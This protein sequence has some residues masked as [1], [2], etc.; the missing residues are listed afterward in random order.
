MEELPTTTTLIYYAVATITVG[1]AWT[2][3]ANRL[4]KLMAPEKTAEGWY[5]WIVRSIAVLLC[6]GVGWYIGDAWGAI[7]GGMCGLSL[8]QAVAILKKTIQK[9]LDT[10]MTDA[11]RPDGE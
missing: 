8:T 3:W 10:E 9:K 1:W 11:P 6:A 2:E 7:T 5:N 4:L